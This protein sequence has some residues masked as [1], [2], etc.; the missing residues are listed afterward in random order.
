MTALTNMV[1]ARR[2]KKKKRKKRHM[3][4]GGR[5]ARNESEKIKKNK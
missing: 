2:K 4:N 1:I 3:E 5:M